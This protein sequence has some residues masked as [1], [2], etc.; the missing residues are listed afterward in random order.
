MTPSNNIMED[1]I[2]IGLQGRQVKVIIRP[3]EMEEEQVTE[4]HLRVA[5]AHESF[6]EFC[7]G[8]MT[9]YDIA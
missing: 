5:L 1:A 3:A 6:D 2:E 8:K 4:N 7:K 9:S